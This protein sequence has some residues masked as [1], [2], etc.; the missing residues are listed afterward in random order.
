MAPKIVV[1]AKTMSIIKSY[2]CIASN[3]LPKPC[4]DVLRDSQHVFV[5]ST[6]AAWPIWGEWQILEDCVVLAFET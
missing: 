4:P 6:I 1:A 2:V 3:P 5:E